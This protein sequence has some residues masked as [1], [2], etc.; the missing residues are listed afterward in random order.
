VIVLSSRDIHVEG[1][2]TQNLLSTRKMDGGRNTTNDS[3]FHFRLGV[4]GS[5][6]PKEAGKFTP[7]PLIPPPA[8]PQIFIDQKL[9]SLFFWH[10]TNCFRTAPVQAWP[11]ETTREV[12]N[13]D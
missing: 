1:L 5:S 9:K 7:S 13:H 8:P 3:I 11:G 2:V 4:K 12:C 6:E 10:Q